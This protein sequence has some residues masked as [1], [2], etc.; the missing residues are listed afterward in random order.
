MGMPHLQMCESILLVPSTISYAHRWLAAC[1]CICC[2][3]FQV[4]ELR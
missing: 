3:G 1:M 4:C 2:K